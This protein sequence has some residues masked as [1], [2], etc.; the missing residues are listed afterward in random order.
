[1]TNSYA[2]LHRTKMEE[3]MDSVS[4]YM[5]TKKF[6]T[7]LYRKIK[8]YYRHYYNKRTALDEQTLVFY[9]D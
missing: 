8:T 1:M 5:K 7:Y 4:N 3:K 2:T 6:P 9:I